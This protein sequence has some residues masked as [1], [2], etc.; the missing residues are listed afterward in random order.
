MSDGSLLVGTDEQPLVHPTAHR[1]RASD[2]RRL[3]VLVQK[4]AAIVIAIVGAVVSFA[5]MQERTGENTRRLEKLEDAQSLLATKADL[6]R[7]EAG[8]TFLVQRELTKATK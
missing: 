1:R 2:S 7:V 5:V 8:V 6:A 3:G 4:Y